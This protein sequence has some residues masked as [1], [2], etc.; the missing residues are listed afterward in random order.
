MLTKKYGKP[1]DEVERF[2]SYSK[3]SDDGSRMIQVQLDKC[4]YYTIFSTPKGDIELS[5]QHNGVTS[6]FVLLKY[7]DKINTNAVQEDA[8]NDL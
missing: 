4:K 2:D 3:P 1:S 6:C 5:I 7:Y 8:M